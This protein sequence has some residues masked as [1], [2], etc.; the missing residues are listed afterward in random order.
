[1]LHVA[2]VTTG[3]ILNKPFYFKRKTEFYSSFHVKNFPILA[4]VFIWFSKCDFQSKVLS[5]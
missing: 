2:F 4:F 3:Q 5:F 1:M